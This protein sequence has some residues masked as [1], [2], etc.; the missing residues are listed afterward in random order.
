MV[1]EGL[2]GGLDAIGATTVVDRVEVVAQDLLLGLLP[3]DLDGH[4]GL[5]EL[6]GVGA[7]GVDV[8]VL[9]VLLRQG[10]GA[11]GVASAQ[12][13]DQGARDALGVDALVGVEGAV[14][15][16]HHRVTHIV[17]Q[18][19]GIHGLSVD[20]GELPHLRGSVGVVDRAALSQ[21]EL[22]GLGHLDGVIGPH[23]GADGA[24]HPQQEDA[25][26]EPPAGDPAMDLP[27]AGAGVVEET[28]L[29]PRG[30]VLGALG[31]R[32]LA[33]LSGL[34]TA[35]RDPAQGMPTGAGHLGQLVA[36]GA[37][38]S[39]PTRAF[40]HALLVSV[41]CHGGD[42]VPRRRGG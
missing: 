30:G 39:A 32:L 2:R 38:G 34:L 14:L 19:G 12:V 4:D 23:E 21:R 29:A 5:L 41:D 1:E 36:D 22:T 27:L 13:V 25:Q 3:V 16:G 20:L 42:W 26:D 28:A 6:A 33:P 40:C 37:A 35:P 31:L 10:R 15:R 24:E 18:G 9:H 11:L 7:G 8:V 17:R